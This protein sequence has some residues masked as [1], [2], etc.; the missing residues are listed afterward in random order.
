MPKSLKSITQSISLAEKDLLNDIKHELVNVKNN[1]SS[2]NVNTDTLEAKIQSTNDKLDSFS[3]HTNNTGAIGD[4]STQLRTVPLGY[5]RANGKAIS[6]LIDS[7]GHQQ[8]DLV[9]GGD[10]KST[11]DTLSGAG[12]N[13]VGE[14]QTKLQIFNY[15]RD[16]AAGNYKPM[17]V[18][19]DG[20]QEVRLVGNTSAD[21]TGTSN[22]AHV[23]GS[24]ILKVSNV[25]T[26]NVAPANSVNGEMTP[27]QSFNV[28]VAAAIPQSNFKLEDL[29]S[30]IN[31]QHASG[32]TRSIAVGLKGTT[33]ISDVPSGSKFLLCSSLGELNV[34][35]SL[36][37]TQIASS[38]S[39]TSG[40]ATD[41]SVLEVKTKTR[42]IS[43]ILEASD[44]GS[45]YTV[46]FS[47]SPDNGTYYT[48]SSNYVTSHDSGNSKQLVIKDF[49]IR[50]IK[51]VIT[52]STGS[53]KTVDVY[54]HY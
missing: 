34:V 33:D 40:A 27:T 19:G 18:D 20:R 10:I 39:L 17:K 7:L 32:T 9:S 30:S 42:G 4:G 46:T 29:S 49:E 5:D 23:D 24:G 35:N 26:Q 50:Y 25:S 11:L 2:V 16:T 53:T 15:G 45:N 41:T 54:A 52:Q 44:I 43:F 36:T 3:G 51:M 21:G 13:N 6:F 37:T 38:L 47:V 22:H 28:R 12:N 1:T 31:A 48:L 8:V 14:G